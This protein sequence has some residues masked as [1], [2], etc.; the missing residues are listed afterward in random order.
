[1]F[2]GFRY[3]RVPLIIGFIV[4][5]SACP[6]RVKDKLANAPALTGY[7]SVESLK[8]QEEKS[9]QPPVQ[10]SEKSAQ[11][12]IEKKEAASGIQVRLAQEYDLLELLCLDEK[13]TFEFFKPLYE[14]YYAD[15][16]KDKNVEKILRFELADDIGLFQ[17]AI[18]AQ[19]LKM[20]TEVL[21]CAYDT[22]K[23]C[24]VGLAY[25]YQHQACKDVQFDGG[26]LLVDSNYRGRGIGKAL[27]LKVLEYYKDSADA[28]SIYIFKRG[29]DKTIEF[30]KKLGFVRVGPAPS[31][32]LHTYYGVPY[33]TMCDEYRY[34]NKGRMP[35]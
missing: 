8:P 32:Y 12:I 24:C 4:I 7:V 34:Q 15:V 3:I 22:E 18:E 19:A 26:L 1:M 10:Q 35:I 31:D 23:K 16:F 5:G 29:N 6:Y 33:A 17:S 28:C 30:Y 27:V 21:F 11:K 9:K 2:L 14:H 20:R 25:A 13:I